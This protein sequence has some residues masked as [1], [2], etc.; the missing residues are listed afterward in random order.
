MLGYIAR[1][2]YM[3]KCTGE[4]RAFIR[5]TH[6]VAHKFIRTFEVIIDPYRV[7]QYSPFDAVARVSMWVLEN[8]ERVTQTC[9]DFEGVQH[10]NTA[11][12]FAAAYSLRY[13][14]TPMALGFINVLDHIKEEVDN[15]PVSREFEELGVDV[16][17]FGRVVR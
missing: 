16:K 15:H 17:Q 2:W 4:L 6:P 11:F 5:V 13:P 10:V 3:S 9:P 7:V 14:E 1:T 8:R 12:S